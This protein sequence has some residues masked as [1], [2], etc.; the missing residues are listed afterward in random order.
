MVKINFFFL[1]VIHMIVNLSK[2]SPSP[3]SR[4]LPL[5]TK[6]KKKTLVFRIKTEE[7][8]TKSTSILRSVI[9]GEKSYKN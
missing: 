5:K 1:V 4:R 2:L 6:K 8:I 9:A 7:K 3:G